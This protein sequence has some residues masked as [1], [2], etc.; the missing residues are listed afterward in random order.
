MSRQTPLYSIILALHPM[1]ESTRVLASNDVN[2]DVDVD[3][4]L[5][6]L[7][8]DWTDYHGEKEI[9]DDVDASDSYGVAR[10]GSIMDS[11]EKDEWLSPK[12]R[13]RK[14]GRSTSSCSSSNQHVPPTSPVASSSA[15]AGDHLE[16]SS[17]HSVSLSPSTESQSA[18]S[19]FFLNVNPPPPRRQTSG[20]TQLG[21]GIIHLYKHDRPMG[22][23]ESLEADAVNRDTSGFGH[24]FDE[25]KSETEHLEHQ[26]HSDTSNNRSGRDLPPIPS[27]PD[28]EDGTLV[29]ILAVPSWMS[30]SEFEDFLGAWILALEGYRRII[31]ESSRNKSMVLLKFLDPERATDFIAV[32]TSKAFAAQ[33]MTSV[34]KDSKQVKA[35]DRAETCHPIRIYHLLME[36]VSLIKPSSDDALSKPIPRRNTDLKVLLKGIPQSTVKELPT[37]PNC[38][39]RLDSTITG[40]IITPCAHVF[41]CQCLSKWGRSNCRVCHYTHRSHQS[42]VS[43]GNGAASHP[44]HN[45]DKATLAHSQCQQCT[46]QENDSKTNWVCVICGYIGCSRYK[47]GHAR[48]HFLKQGHAYSMEIETQRVWDYGEDK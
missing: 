21:P 18:S 27:K 36:R 35:K 37:C 30:R 41:H 47:K 42:V 12:T 24:E 25:L 4:R 48:D 9:D 45:D 20:I 29:A 34:S 3:R 38:L 44:L 13:M 7:E 17:L 15:S 10:L 46:P 22:V 23:L 2:V 11:L 26:H 40:L 33:S 32:Y 16:T 28:G 39:E 31:D 6:E 43:S 8:I 19:S 1:D 5:G 14:P